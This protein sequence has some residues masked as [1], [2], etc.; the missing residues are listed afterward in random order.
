VTSFPPSDLERLRLRNKPAGLPLI[1]QTWRQLAFLHWS[2][3]PVALAALLPAGIE[4]DT[5][6]GKAY[7]GLVPFAVRRS[8]PAF[9]PPVPLTA[10]FSELNLRTYVHRRGRNPG[11]WFFSLDATSRL[12]VWGAR[13]IYRLPYFQATIAMAISDGATSF[14]S[15]RGTGAGRPRFACSYA[16]TSAA[17]EAAPGTLEFFLIERYLLYSAGGGYLRK[18]RVWHRPYPLA[19]AR[20]D[21]L[22]EDVSAAA[23]IEI[24]PDQAPIAHYAE[25]LDVQIYPPSL[26][27]EPVQ[28]PLPE[29]VQATQ[30]L[31]MSA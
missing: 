24:Q 15:L 8:R 7:V 31:P 3:D 6:E 18:A 4:L 2:V 30:S 5:W 13:A 12:A 29:M 23:G 21:D 14:S 1:R 19:T 9:L 28:D 11:V 25:G 20:I 16:A 17:S 26:V 10:D 22:R 27:E